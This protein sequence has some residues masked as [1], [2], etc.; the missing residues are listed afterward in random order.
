M[1]SYLLRRVPSAILVLLF[2]SM[3]IFAVIRLV[4]GDPATILAGQDASP[5]ALA[6]IRADLGLDQPVLTQYLT[7]LAGMIRL[8]PGKS[9][10]IGGDIGGLVRAGLLNTVVLTATAL[11]FAVVLAGLAAIGSVLANRRWLD[12]VLAGA[13]TLAVA[14]PTFVT[15]VLFVVV[16][17]VILPILP[18]GGTPPDGFFS[19]PGIAFQY[20]VLPALCLALPSAAALARFLTASLQTELG[21]PYVTTAQALGIRRR[22]IVLTQALPNALPATVTVLGLQVGALLGGAVLVEAIFA[23]PG[24]GLLIERAISDRDYP[25]VQALLLLSVLVFVVTQ[26]LTDIVNAVLDPRIR[27]GGAS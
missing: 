8:D 2:A 15:G 27:L 11:L 7:W 25:L 26:L 3:A 14:L 12:S 4:P 13:N 17:A 10:M 6:S 5:E 16:F 9:Y 22:R 23:W 21:K 24:L 20:L 19:R 1:T 18:A